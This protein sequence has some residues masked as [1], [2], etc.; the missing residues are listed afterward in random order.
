MS[1][2][3]FYVFSYPHKPYFSPQLPTSGFPVPSPWSCFLTHSPYPCSLVDQGG[4]GPR[5]CPVVS[6]PG[7]IR[8]HSH[9]QVQTPQSRR[10]ELKPVGRNTIS[11]WVSE[12]M[13]DWG[14]DK[15][16]IEGRVRRGWWT[17][18]R[19]EIDGKKECRRMIKQEKDNENW[20][21]WI[22]SK[23]LN[24]KRLK[25]NN[26]NKH[27]QKTTK[28]ST[29]CHL[30][31]GGALVSQLLQGLCW[32]WSGEVGRLLQLLGHLLLLLLPHA[33]VHV[34]TAATAHLGL[35]CEVTEGWWGGGVSG[36]WDGIVD[37]CMI[38]RTSEDGI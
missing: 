28:A 18:E 21:M 8:T 36:C 26:I 32:A 7:W 38:G 30:V 13:T 11:K 6:L 9:S 15:E 2:F 27:K 3:I 35:N 4:D 37:D 34:C 1:L 14:W 20:K 33:G 22:L 10:A 24:M 31:I 29:H 23:I 5:P 16:R 25:Q 19:E 17:R 12:C